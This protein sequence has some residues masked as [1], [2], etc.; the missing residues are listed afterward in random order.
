MELELLKQ[1]SEEYDISIDR[2]KSYYASI[3]NLPFVEDYGEDMLMEC[4]EKIV[5]D[6]KT[7]EFA[8]QQFKDTHV[9]STKFKPLQYSISDALYTTYGDEA[10]PYLSKDYVIENENRYKM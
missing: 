6:V 9:P 10:I 2:V 3:I 1:L 8:K 5:Q 4:L 7:N